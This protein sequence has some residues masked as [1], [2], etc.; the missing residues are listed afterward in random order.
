MPSKSR[1]EI[2]QGC[3]FSRDEWMMAAAFGSITIGTPGNFRELPFLD[4]YKMEL[5]TELRRDTR[6]NP[7]FD[8]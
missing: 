5:A 2:G 3:E 1:R 6:R 7:F 8:S 4:M